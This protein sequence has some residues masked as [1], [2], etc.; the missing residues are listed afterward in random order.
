MRTFFAAALL[1]AGCSQP[2]TPPEPTPAPPR[3]V[4]VEPE[5]VGIGELW[6]AYQADAAAAERLYGGRSIRVKYGVDSVTREV[7]GFLVTRTTHP[8]V[9]HRIIHPASAAR[10]LEGATG[11][12]L[13]SRG[14]VQSAGRTGIM[15]RV[16]R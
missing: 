12:A 11:A 3:P 16:D 1:A 5:P 15:F 8:N 14:K 6:E 7:Y 10:D 9:T 13:V 2:S 4:A